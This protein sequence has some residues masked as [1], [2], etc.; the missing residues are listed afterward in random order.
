[1]RPHPAENSYWNVTDRQIGAWNKY[2]RND[3]RPG[4]VY[5][6]AYDAADDLLKIGQSTR[7]AAARARELND[8]CGTENPGR[9]S[10]LHEVRTVDCGRAE[11]RAHKHLKRHRFRKEYFRIDAATA[12]EAVREACAF[13]DR[14]EDEKRA[15]DE[16]RKAAAAAAQAATK[17]EQRTEGSALSPEEEAAIYAGLTASAK[18][19]E[20]RERHREKAQLPNPK[21]A[22]LAAEKPKFSPPEATHLAQAPANYTIIKCP[23]CAQQLRTPTRGD[24][25]LTCP[26]CR[27]SF[28]RT[29][30]GR[31]LEYSNYSINT[32]AP[33]KART[34]LAVYLTAALSAFLGVS[35][36]VGLGRSNEVTESTSTPLPPEERRLL[37]DIQ[38]YAANYEI[39]PP[40]PKGETQLHAVE[41]IGKGIRFQYVTT[42]RGERELSKNLDQQYIQD[43]MRKI[44]CAKP[45]LRALM[46]RGAV[47]QYQLSQKSGATLTT[48]IACE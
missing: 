29:A 37:V 39:P 9:F 6:L 21:P 11:K 2:N 46:D 5:I 19:F 40:D 22:P 24:L 30:D 1:M 33:S 35:A 20:P 43:G 12:L 4:V 47:V 17:V 3:G 16:A 48:N 44:A 28:E 7:S 34:P 26:T 36:I 38:R 23:R 14:K 27:Y 31:L 25:I 15:A 8:K 10:V 32:Q 13:F 18:R 41:R 42:A 45:E